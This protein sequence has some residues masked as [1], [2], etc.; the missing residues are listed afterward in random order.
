MKKIVI[1]LVSAVLLIILSLLLWPRTPQFQITAKKVASVS[2][3]PVVMIRTGR[4]IAQLDI[5]F[6]S[7][8]GFEKFVQK[9][10]DEKVRFLAGTNVVI[11]TQMSSKGPSDRLQLSYSTFE[12]AQAVA[13]SLHR[14]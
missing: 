14:K 2:V 5:V 8:S 4:T 10:L 1:V 3:Q 6:S 13:D 12:E 11:E 7:N 9:H